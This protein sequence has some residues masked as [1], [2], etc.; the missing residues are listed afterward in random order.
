MVARQKHSVQHASLC[1]RYLTLHMCL[2]YS[3]PPI[4]LKNLAYEKKSSE[5]EPVWSIRTLWFYVFLALTLSRV[6]SHIF[7]PTP[8]PSQSS[9]SIWTRTC[10]CRIS[11]STA[12]HSYQNTQLRAL[13]LDGKIWKKDTRTWQRNVERASAIVM[14][15]LN[16][17]CKWICDL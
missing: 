9:V 10:I 12:S 13:S 15:M 11:A 14:C 16:W 2:L 6:S 4:T 8:A 17:F 7:F 5:E 3:W 1:V